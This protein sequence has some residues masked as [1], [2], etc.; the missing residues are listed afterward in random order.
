RRQRAAGTSDVTAA[1][2]E[3]RVQRQTGSFSA[4]GNQDKGHQSAIAAISTG[5]FLS[6][7]LPASD[8]E[9][10]HPD[11]RHVFSRQT[12]T[13]PADKLART[14]KSTTRTGFASV[15]KPSSASA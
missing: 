3:P 4:P 5:L 10:S 14:K 6:P 7:C 8:T 13:S 11:V 2:S 15:R 12:R 9:P 1:T